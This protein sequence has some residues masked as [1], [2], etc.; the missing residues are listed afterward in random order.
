MPRNPNADSTFDAYLAEVQRYPLLTPAEEREL[1]RAVQRHGDDHPDAMADAAAARD[2]MIK[3]N[4]RLVISIAKRYAG[5]GLSLP[6][7]VEEGNLGLVHAVE[8][9]DP[10]METRFSTYATWWIKQAIRRAIVNTVKTVRIPSYLTDELNRWR[11]FAR[12]FEQAH[13]RAPEDDELLDAMKPMPGRRR[14]LLR[15]FRTGGPGA[16][17]ASLDLLF[18][19][20]EAVVDPRAERPD[21]IDFAVWER[22]GLL[23]RVDG[24]PER[25]RRILKL[26][27]GLEAMGTPLTLRET[28]RRMGLSRERVRQ[29]EHEA[30]RALREALE[31][32]GPRAGGR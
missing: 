22:E 23:A 5:R 6:D 19:G 11:A 27:Y 13:G 1:A 7:L 32:P 9:F 3:H 16:A 18:E 26:R 12:T 30:L 20:V 10:E 14:L 4:L 17:T 24:L 21:L 2:R 31:G 28:A 15:L 25:E 8:K 29:L